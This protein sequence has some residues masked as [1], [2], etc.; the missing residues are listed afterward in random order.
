[1][2]AG[3][4]TERFSGA[5]RHGVNGPRGRWA[6]WFAAGVLLLVACSDDDDATDETQAPASTT[7]S[8]GLPG[9]APA[10]ATTVP[11]SEPALT[12]GYLAPGVGLLNALG[13][14]QQRGLTLAVDEINAAGGVL[15]GPV[16][17]VTTEESADRPIDAVLDD[18]VAQ[19]PD[20]IVGPVGSSSAVALAPLLAERSLLACS[21]SATATSLTGDVDTESDA[22]LTSVRTALRDDQFARLVAD[23]LMT[24]DDKRDPAPETL[25]IVGRDDVYGNE[26]MAGLSAELTARGADVSTL[27]YPPRRVDFLEEAGAVVAGD[28]DVV[29]LAAYTEAPRLIAR[30]VE[31]GY[32]ADRI[33]GLDGLLVPRLAEQTFPSDPARADGVRVIGTTGD[34]ALMTRLA[35]VPASDDQLSYG[36]QMYDCVI[37]LALAAEAS[38]STEPAAIAQQLGPV[39][40][41]GRTCSTFAHC[42]ELLEAGEDIDYDGTTGR[43][44]LDASGDITTARLVNGAV[45]DGQLQPVTTRDVDLVAERQQEIFDSAVFVAQLQQALKVLG[46]YDGDV[47]GVYDDATTA[48]VEALQ[49]DLDLP[50][51]GK[52]DEATDAALRQRLGDRLDTFTGAVS[53]LQEALTELGYYSGPIDGRYSAA[54]VVAVKAFQKDLGV[55]ATG[56]IDV[57]TLRAIY[58][59][60]QETGAASEPEPTTTTTSRPATTV[61]TP[62]AAPTTAQPPPPTEAPLTET[63]RP[64]DGRSLYEVLSAD[65][66]YSMLV[67]VAQAAGYGGDFS[68][69]GPFTLFA[70]TNDAFA[71]LDPDRLDELR[72]D[73]E[74]ADALLRDLAVEGAIPSDELTTGELETIGGAP[75]DVVVDG[76]TVTYAGATVVE[77]D[78]TASN[79]VAH[80]VDAVPE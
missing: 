25:T 50:E 17:V 44:A 9:T 39:T 10:P 33:V 36:P 49:R 76:D 11:E 34:R 5:E 40:A 64:P 60:G 74:A 55:P 72:E 53:D 65:R 47:T 24:T 1:V 14:G 80:G 68:Q 56:V 31:A 46:F 75:V 59:R 42:V 78:I 6:A 19:E 32:D 71:A 66:N 30:I 8:P 62:P 16:A 28:P 3:S 58:A 77:P 38:A 54:T 51:T 45:S 43:I 57:A 73:A 7:T 2:V 52:Y 27:T 18:L 4:G 26:L 13:I 69:P 61:T 37:T 22:P 41:D 63:T 12:I 29:L 15:A 48:A 20:V 21:A 67:E 79:G 23:E 70:P 35:A